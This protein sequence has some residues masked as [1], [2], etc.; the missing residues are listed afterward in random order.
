M[1]RDR[2]DAGRQLAIQLAEYAHCTD[3]LVMGLLRGGVPV[4]FEISQALHAPLDILSVCKLG[5]PG[6]PELAMGAVATG[7]IRILDLAMMDKL[8]LGQQEL[9]KA[10]ALKNI[11]L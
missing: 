9:E 11:E 2:F 1:F 3:V 8:K 4:G 5:T 7:G 6:Q 10:A